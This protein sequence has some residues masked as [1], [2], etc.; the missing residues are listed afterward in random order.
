[1]AAVIVAELPE[2]FRSEVLECLAGELREDLETRLAAGVEVHDDVLVDL[3]ETLRDRWRDAE[4]R[5]LDDVVTLHESSPSAPVRGWSSSEVALLQ[6]VEGI[7]SRFDDL[8]GVDA[9]I[10]R[11]VY[12]LVGPHPF[13]QA[14]SGSDIEIR[15]T[16]L[17]R[18]APLARMELARQIEQQEPVRLVDIQRS[19]REVLKHAR[20]FL[21]A[22]DP[23]W[24]S[25]EG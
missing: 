20:R 3:A 18:L 22:A 16:I 6:A 15:R 19:Q 23:S 1:V 9:T 17:E 12:D 10:I 24:L 14:L 4:S 2:A 5:L 13:R 21:A 25:E 7:L 11:S 8:I